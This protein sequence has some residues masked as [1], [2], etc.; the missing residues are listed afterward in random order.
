MVVFLLL[1]EALVSTQQ[2]IYTLHRQCKNLIYFRFNYILSLAKQTIETCL[3]YMLNIL[4][5]KDSWIN[6]HSS[7]HTKI[8]NDY[9]Y[10]ER[11]FLIRFIKILLRHILLIIY[12]KN[13]NVSNFIAKPTHLYLENLLTSEIGYHHQRGQ[14]T[15]TK[16]STITSNLMTYVWINFVIFNPG[17]QKYLRENKDISTSE[18]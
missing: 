13:L 17:S 9:V 3:K 15:A 1:W 18:C 12:N 8:E 6:Q 7:N 11:L 4:T 2:T 10:E 14:E 16:H 5:W